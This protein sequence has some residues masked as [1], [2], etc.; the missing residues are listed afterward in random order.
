MVTKSSPRRGSE[1]AVTLIPAV[2]CAAFPAREFKADALGSASPA[3][4]PAAVVNSKH[5][6]GFPIA[7]RLLARPGVQRDALGRSAFDR[8]RSRRARRA[9]RRLGDAEPR[10]GRA[11]GDR[12]RG[13]RAALEPR[14]AS[15]D[16]RRAPR[17]LARGRSAP[18]STPS[19]P[20]IA[21]RPG[22]APAP[23]PRF[24]GAPR[25]EAGPR[26]AKA[27]YKWKRSTSRRARR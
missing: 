6:H 9:R 3:S 5:A 20:P 12:A 15:P 7:N 10:R 14:P 24:E 25:G 13:F 21:C 23:A 16:G 1:V 2:E 18:R 17:P 22:A 27:T 4:R 8:R 11:C 26:L 19:P